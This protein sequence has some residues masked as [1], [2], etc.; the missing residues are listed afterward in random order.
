MAMV[1]FVARA[2]SQQHPKA[3][4]RLSWSY[5]W[6]ESMLE[7]RNTGLKFLA[8]AHYYNNG[9]S[10]CYLPASTRL[11]MSVRTSLT[12]KAGIFNPDFML[13]LCANLRIDRHR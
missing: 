12:Q 6:D 2:W 9:P 1:T 5:K 8:L 13:I 11:F 7:V 4:T 10:A 3:K